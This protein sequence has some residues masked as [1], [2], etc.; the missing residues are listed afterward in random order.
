MPN[1]G[2]DRDRHPP[3]EVFVVVVAKLGDVG[4]HVEHG[5]HADVVL[6]DGSGGGVGLEDHGAA[7]ADPLAGRGGDG[8]GGDA[9]GEEGVEGVREGG[10]VRDLHQAAL[11]V[12]DELPHPT[13]T[14]PT[15]T[16]APHF[17]VL[18]ADAAFSSSLL[19]LVFVIVRHC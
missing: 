18:V 17:L 8:D 14:E 6:A 9:V 19:L 1:D 12:A 2:G 7:R 13:V 15:V 3:V 5:E 16:A 4:E 10:G 11:L